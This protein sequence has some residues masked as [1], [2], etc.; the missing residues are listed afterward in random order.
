MFES[1]LA[2]AEASL[3][4]AVRGVRENGSS[5]SGDE[6]G[7]VLEATRSL[8]RWVAQLQVEAVAAMERSGVFTEHGYRRPESAVANLLTVERGRARRV[9]TAAES[10]CARVDL[11]GQVL[12]PRLPATAAAFSSGRAGLRHVDVIAAVMGSPAARRLDPDTWAGVEA[13]VATL[14]DEYTPSELASWG[15]KLVEVCDQDGAEPDDGPPAPANELRLTRSSGGGGR[16]KGRFDDPVRFAMITA[17]LDAKSRPSTADDERSTA[18]RRA[19][20]L[21]DACGFVADHADSA[22]LPSSGGQRPHI[23]VTV[24]L[25]DLENRARAA[26]LD[27]GGTPSPAALRMLCCDASV[28]P[29]VLNGA[30]Q[31]LDV[32][33]ATRT[34][35]DGLRRAVT[36]RDG[37]CAHPG[38]DRP[39]SWSEIHHIQEWAHGGGTRLDNLVMLC[40]THH[41]EIHSTGWVV[42]IAADGIPEFIPPEW[43]D[44]NRRPRRRPRIPFRDRRP[45][46]TGPPGRPGR[47]RPRRADAGSRTP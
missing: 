31:P 8:D 1:G 19:D 32:G 3:R 33:R 26:C 29:V 20:A 17:V 43:L 9:V 44:R 12:P 40:R 4:E 6:L 41:R 38:C 23:T 18:E 27:V 21:A 11:Q 28:V 30:G 34:I 22:A 5:A 46:A 15:T 47:S 24:T 36:A 16:L 45:A 14:A 2:I 37:G 25:D 42:R 39:P 35:P 7:A 10:V 13:Q